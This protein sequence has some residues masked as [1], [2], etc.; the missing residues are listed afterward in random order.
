MRI[1]RIVVALVVLVV[2]SAGCASVRPHKGATPTVEVGVGFNMSQLPQAEFP[3]FTGS[4][5]VI[6]PS[7]STRGMALVADVD[8]SY[9]MS[10]TVAGLRAYGRSGPLFGERKTMTYFAHLLV[11]AVHGSMQGVLRSEGGFAVQPGVGLDY[12]AG[13]RAFRVQ[14]DYRRVASG[15]V[16]DS[17][18]PGRPVDRLSGPRVV[19]GMTWRLRPR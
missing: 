14:V 3:G 15:V 7:T 5:A 6:R 9:L 19:L 13:S 11:G 12:G 2:P 8:A 18:V 17:R 1:P 10:S 4:V 16:Y